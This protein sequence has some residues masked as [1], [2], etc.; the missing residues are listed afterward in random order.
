MMIWAL[1]NF[2][3]PFLVAGVAE[4]HDLLAKRS[5]RSASDHNARTCSAK[6]DPVLSST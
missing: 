6:P 4:L 5:L 1:T 3:A 2:V